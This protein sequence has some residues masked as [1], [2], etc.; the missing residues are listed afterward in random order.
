MVVLAVLVIGGVA[1]TRMGLDLLPDI[2]FPVMAIVTVYPG[3]GPDAVEQHVTRPIETTLASVAGVS[4]TTSISTENLSLVLTELNWGTNLAVASSDVDEALQRIRLSLPTSIRP[5]VVLRL[6]PTQ[7]PIAM[8]ALRLAEASASGAAPAEDAAAGLSRLTRAATERVVP[9]LERVDGV[10]RVAVSGGT[11]DEVD[12]RYDPEE[13]ARAGLSPSQL[14]QLITYQ[15][16]EVPVGAITQDGRRYQVRAG[17]PIRSVDDLAAL[18]VTI[19][20]PG[21]DAPGL[22]PRVVTVQDVADVGLVQRPPEGYGRLN[23]HPSLLLSVW[24]E[25]GQNTVTVARRIQRALETGGP[26]LEG[27]E[28]VPVF[29]QADFIVRSLS[30]VSTS[31][32]VGGVLAIV[33]LYLFLFDILSTLTIAIAIPISLVAT[34]AL[35]FLDGMTLNLMSLGGLGL[36]I[37]M[38]VDNSIV[39]LESIFR[40]VHQGEAPEVAARRGTAEV[41]MA[42]TASTLTTLV[43]F[44]PVVFVGGLAGRIFREL[45]ITVSFSLL[46][47]L[48][49]A[50]TVVPAMASRLG[51]AQNTALVRRVTELAL[52]RGGSGWFGPVRGAYERALRWALA[53]RAAVAGAVVALVAAG[54]A[55]YPVLDVEFLTPVDMGQLGVTVEMPPGT[56]LER[57]DAVT[58][59]VEEVAA[60]IPEVQVVGTVVGSAGTGDL[61]SVLGGG[62]TST[63]TLTL[64]LAPRSQRSHSASEV[65]DSLRLRLQAELAD[66]PEAQVRV[67]DAPSFGVLSEFL[68]QKVT[69]HV[70][71]SDAAELE[72]IAGEV[73]ERMRRTPG[74]INVTTSLTT[75]EPAVLLEIEPGR[76][77]FGGMVAGQIG[78]ALREAVQGTPAGSL[79]LEDGRTVPVV[80]RARPEAVASIDSLME[81]RLAGLALPASTTPR[82]QVGRV[83]SPQETLQEAAIQHRDGQRIVTITAELSGIQLGEAGNRAQAILQSVATSPRHEVAL[84]GIHELIQEAFGDMWL[85][86]VLAAVLVYMVM[87][88]QFE[89]LLDPLIIMVT[90]PMGLAGGL[91]GLW[92][93]GQAVGVTAILGGVILAGIVVNNGIVLVDY[94]NQVAARAG[95]APGHGA[96]SYLDVVVEAS[97]VRLRPVLMTALT[98]IL[99]LLPLTLGWGDATE[100]EVPLAVTVVGGMVLATFLTLFVVPAAKV[101]LHALEECG[102]VRRMSP[103][104]AGPWMIAVAAMAG[105]LLA[106]AMAGRAQAAASPSGPAAE[107][108]VRSIPLVLARWQPQSAIAGGGVGW[109]P[110][111]ES[112]CGAWIGVLEQARATGTGAGSQGA[113]LRLGAGGGYDV[114]ALQAAAGASAYFAEAGGLWM[115]HRLIA[116]V[117][118][119]TAGAEGWLQHRAGEGLPSRLDAFAR[120]Q[121]SGAMGNTF[122]AANAWVGSA[123]FH[124]RTALLADPFGAALDGYPDPGW[125]VD[126]TGRYRVS[127]ERY[128][129]FHLGWTS[130]GPDPAGAS[131]PVDTA[132]DGLQAG[133]G[134]EEQMG[135]LVKVRAGAGLR[136][137]PTLGRVV[138]QL[139]SGLSVG[140]RRL[141]LS[142][143]GGYDLSGDT[144]GAGPSAPMPVPASLAATLSM[145]SSPG[146][147]L[148]AGVRTPPALPGRAMDGS[149]PAPALLA[150]EAALMV[151][152][153]APSRG[154][155]PPSPLSEA[156]LLLTFE[157][158]WGRAGA[159]V[160][161]RF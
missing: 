136:Y 68:S 77:L 102:R 72:R 148:Q 6:D 19:Q 149:M 64:I 122:V 4:R 74:F 28:L 137:S 150:P 90:V 45:A 159:M 100:L 81:L 119:M 2:E 138:P 60:A 21:P 62:S 71:G 85:A 58:R 126:L 123:G 127:R 44:L 104:P 14:A 143:D 151:T 48:A 153:Q 53:H 13:L 79:V 11:T 27:V 139:T 144:P 121:A 16:V 83:A 30:S 107:G 78:G 52:R 20:R 41:G 33:V 99:G 32:A 65:A 50:L 129:R 55:I 146:L 101:S 39:V 5:P 94:I 96:P 92:L 131:R 152:W 46:A 73:V 93:A 115:R 70:R 22:L 106:L 105:T 141:S 135:A 114:T 86:L 113:V 34:V 59:R 43:V 161:F 18:A 12:V 1:L 110:P 29:D 87:A 118:V 111:G 17:A 124:P 24:K 147:S 15:N 9:L 82:V 109:C 154:T 89:S 116:G 49:V 117:G 23:G 134:L 84:A 157:P 38:L 156:Q 108:S 36:G 95:Q 57:T 140:D 132:N 112:L 103:S 128:A 76:A 142:I 88:A 67:T 97:S 130:R 160:T 54:A 158:A 25:S 35:M 31:A 10:A 133:M 47:S 80:V 155:P 69:V 91:M 145:G 120:L 42:I 40:H 61:L 26:G 8:Y 56:P 75:R 37:G 66:V 3:A 51:L 98:T 125:G 63:G 7:M